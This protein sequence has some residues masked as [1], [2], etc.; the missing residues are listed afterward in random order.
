MHISFLLSVFVDIR[1]GF[2]SPCS[3]AFCGNIIFFLS[4]PVTYS[5]GSCGNLMYVEASAILS[6]WAEIHKWI[7]KV[8]GRKRAGMNKETHRE[9]SAE[10]SC[11][12]RKQG[13]S[14]VMELISGTKS[15]LKVQS[16]L[17]Y[18]L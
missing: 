1:H 9:N 6:E 3:L 5:H 18:L 2:G 14:S 13:R 11:F 16:I 7:Q 15:V 4:Y 17:F 10:L 8:L 12:F